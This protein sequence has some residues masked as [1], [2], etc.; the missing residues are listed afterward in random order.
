MFILV[1]TQQFIEEITA[2]IMEKLDI[3]KLEDDT[4]RFTR[5]DVLR[6]GDKIIMQESRGSIINQVENFSSRPTLDLL[7]GKKEDVMLRLRLG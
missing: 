5:I 2:K 7:Q 1:G 4:F 3:S 6:D